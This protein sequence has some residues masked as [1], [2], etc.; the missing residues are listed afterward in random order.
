MAGIVTTSSG[1][2]AIRTYR[3]IFTSTSTSVA[4]NWISGTTSAAG[5]PWSNLDRGVAVVFQN[6]SSAANITV[7]GA[8]VTPNA[9][10]IVIGART[11]TDPGR[12]EIMFGGGP[13]CIQLP[14]W[15][16]TSTSSLAV[17]VAQLIRYV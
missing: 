3:A 5:T 8:D 13:T 2:G 6:Q 17:A 7:G 15:Y 1:S 4:I 14:E 9:Q 12:L 11:A 16:V 10:G